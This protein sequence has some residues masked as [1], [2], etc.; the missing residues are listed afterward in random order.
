FFLTTGI[1]KFRAGQGEHGNDTG[2]VEDCGVQQF[3]RCNLDLV[4]ASEP[5][6]VEL[7][8][9]DR[10]AKFRPARTLG[11]DAATLT[12]DTG[13]RRG[14]VNDVLHLTRTPCNGGGEKLTILTIRNNRGHLS[15]SPARLCEAFGLLLR[16]C[17]S[18]TSS[19]PALG[20]CP[21]WHRGK[22]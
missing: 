7:V 5:L 1:E 17:L 19:Y 15:L 20:Y 9:H 21:R 8:K 18:L 3:L 4:V 13:K 14:I 16:A 10:N 12:K 2:P 22:T 11:L 6:G